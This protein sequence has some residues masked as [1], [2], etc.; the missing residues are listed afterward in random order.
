MQPDERALFGKNIII[1]LLAL[2]PA[3]ALP[4]FGVL[5]SP[6][7]LKLLIVAIVGAVLSL[8]FF[9][10]P[11]T[12]LLAAIFYIYS[13]LSYYSSMHLGYPLVVI[14]FVALL[15]QLFRGA[16]LES[17]DRA[18]VLLVSLF[19]LFAL[20]S[21]MFSHNLGYSWHSFSMYLKV[22]VLAF[23]AV[24]LL[25]DPRDLEMFAL[26]IFA[27][28]VFSVILGLANLKLGLARDVTVV[29]PA[30]IMRFEAT[31][32][33]P[34]IMAMYLVTAIPLGFYAVR[35]AHRISLR[36]LSILGI[37]LL[38]F[39]VFASFS[40][41]AIFPLGFVVLAAL[42]REVKSR[43]LY[44]GIFIA[45]FV[46]LLMVPK[47]YWLRIGSVEELT[48]QITFDRSFVLRR[49]ALEAAFHIFLQHPI[50]GIGLNNFLARAGSELFVRIWVHNAY[51]EILVGVGVFGFLAF[52]GIFLVGIR[53][54]CRA[55]RARWG[56]E[57]WFMQSLSFY[58]A[59]SLISAMICMLFSSRT[60]AYFLWIPLAGGLVA[61]NVV[62]RCG[63]T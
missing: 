62:K 21:M 53:N 26:V 60:F 50:T 11:K 10:Y 16:S 34:N 35:R 63:T 46:A 33:N 5:F 52:I 6:S 39:A 4:L 56:A 29:G 22:L 20:Q 18:F 57:R 27:G 14:A 13:G 30:R 24:Q 8:I 32:I 31:H 36:L 61:G 38:A 1:Y 43:K 19:T 45:I 23:L 44:I 17:L 48:S 12:G 49:K 3:V 15:F 58:I 47:F 55:V 40:R 2:V 42:F 25:R 41:S 7:I 54:L 37:F 9:A 51:L 59:V 28:G